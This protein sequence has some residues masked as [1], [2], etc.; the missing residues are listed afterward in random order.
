MG[1]TQHDDVWV[2][3][4]PGS[5]SFV[6]AAVAAPVEPG[7]L[8]TTFLASLWWA[9]NLLGPRRLRRALPDHQEGFGVSGP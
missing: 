1:S 3:G 9:E 4:S 8:C 5:A 2:K 6:P 7:L